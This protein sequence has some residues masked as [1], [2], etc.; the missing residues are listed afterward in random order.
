MK[1]KICKTCKQILIP[2]TPNSADLDIT[3]NNSV[4]EI[5]CNNCSAKKTFHVNPKYKMWLD[6]PRSI[7]ETIT[8]SNAG[9]KHNQ[10]S[11]ASKTIEVQVPATNQSK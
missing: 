1:R 9:N 5:R 7:V 8:T 2:G 11:S 3:G 4:C 6:D 10:T